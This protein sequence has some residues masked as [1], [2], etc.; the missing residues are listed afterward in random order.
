[1]LILC[2]FHG[3]RPG[4]LCQLE[5][6]DVTHRNGILCL[7][8]TPS[9]E[10]LEDGE[11]EKSHKTDKSRRIVPVH[12]RVLELGFEKYVATAKEKKL[13][14]L[15]RP[16]ATGRWSQLF[17]RW[18][19]NYL[20]KVGLYRRWRDLYSLRGT[21]KTAARGAR[22]DEEYRDEIAGH[23]NG[24]VGRTYGKIPI[25][26]LKAEVDKINFAVTIPKW[27]APDP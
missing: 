19:S 16:D 13:F 5:K 4:E 22:L 12:K 1:V 17:G 26:I 24:S 10:Q 7:K 6:A 3:Y 9:D 11:V 27:K 15:V 8:L 18:F 2:L 14:P 25:P 21:W 23:E 20:R